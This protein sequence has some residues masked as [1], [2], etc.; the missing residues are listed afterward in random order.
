MNLSAP[1]ARHLRSNDVSSH[2]VSDR[3]TADDGDRSLENRWAAG[4]GLPHLPPAK[5]A[6]ATSELDLVR[7]IDDTRAVSKKKRPR[8]LLEP[9]DARRLY[10]NR[11][12]RVQITIVNVGFKCQS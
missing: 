12:R 5:I 1:R 11:K 9:S 8:T 3:S 4:D 2:C 10:V 7:R 6:Q